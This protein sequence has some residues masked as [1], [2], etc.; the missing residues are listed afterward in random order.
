MHA[1]VKTTDIVVGPLD[2][3]LIGEATSTHTSIDVSTPSGNHRKNK[4]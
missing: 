1:S 3:F 2:L 4:P